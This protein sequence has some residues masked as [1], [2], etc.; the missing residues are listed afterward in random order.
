MQNSKRILFVIVVF[1]VQ[2]L[3]SFHAFS[4]ESQNQSKSTEPFPIQSNNLLDT[5]FGAG[6]HLLKK[7]QDDQHEQQAQTSPTPQTSPASIEEQVWS[8][9]SPI[10]LLNPNFLDRSEIIQKLEDDFNIF[11]QT[12]DPSIFNKY[13]LSYLYSYFQWMLPNERADGSVRIRF[14]YYL[15]ARNRINR[16]MIERDGANIYFSKN[17]G[18]KIITKK[19]HEIMGAVYNSNEVLP[20]EIQVTF[21]YDNELYS[22][23]NAVFL[24]SKDIQNFMYLQTGIVFNLEKTDQEYS[25]TQEFTQREML[26]IL[27]QFLDLP[28]HIRDSLAL[29][30]VIRMADGYQPPFAVMPVA[31]L[32][33]FKDKTIQFFDPAFDPLSGDG[34]G[35]ETILHEIAH[36]LWGQSLWYAFPQHLRDEYQS[37]SWEGEEITGEEFIS[38]Y[39]TKNIKEDFAEHLSMYI[40]HPEALLH[41]TP[42]KY[43]W[44]KE[45]VFVNTEYFSAEA[46]DNLK[47]FVLSDLED[48]TPPY[49]LEGQS[50]LTFESREFSNNHDPSIIYSFNL[51]GLFDDISGVRSINLFF[52]SNDDYLHSKGVEFRDAHKGAKCESADNCSL[53]DS[54]N[55]GVYSFVNTVLL[56]NHKPGTYQLQSIS[57][58]DYS[59]NYNLI[60]NTEK[61]FGPWEFYIP[62]T[63]IDEPKNKQQFSKDQIQYVKDNM[64]VILG[65]THTGDTTAV[66]LLPDVSSNDEIE[67]IIVR[68]KG[69]DTERKLQFFV[70][71]NYLDNI[72]SEFALLGVDIPRRSDFFS[73]P[74][75]I[76]SFLPSEQYDVVSIEYITTKEST[77]ALRCKGEC[78][79]FQHTTNQA[80]HT[81]PQAVAEDIA[82]SI[83]QGPN[84]EG[85]DI[86]ILAHIPVT[87]FEQ[88]LE[89]AISIA[90]LRDPKGKLIGQSHVNVASEESFQFRFDLKP[91]HAQGEYILSYISLTEPHVVEADRIGGWLMSGEEYETIDRLLRRGIRKTIKITIPPYEEGRGV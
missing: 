26:L 68:L 85:G 16:Q 34:T 47:I 22:Q 82:L 36:A 19:F 71:T 62:G 3:F 61:F 73:I 60:P 49:L 43:Q 75:L 90:Q 17:A 1:V 77:L 87:G 29:K 53:F 81:H 76:P 38:E 8:Q 25:V 41:Q 9:I 21:E 51:E 84:N 45:N 30:K 12:D 65:S 83:L 28:I 5:L 37:L 63:R 10:T 13:F 80:D 33:S 56:K 55:P 89:K 42:G 27:T 54:N 15:H 48:V 18:H 58:E 2:N 50:N 78:F 64:E 59:G 88:G 40:D 52:Q 14:P 39:S 7:W 20:D 70:A 23:L 35:E 32:Y 11:I 79:Q 86:S 69:K 72:L 6:K 44:L 91:H 67:T 57:V 24:N 46:L 74:T 4:S 66:F 31:G